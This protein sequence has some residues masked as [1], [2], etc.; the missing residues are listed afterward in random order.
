[1]SV[2][3]SLSLYLGYK[4]MPNLYLYQCHSYALSSSAT[5]TL[6]TTRLP[7]S[8]PVQKQLL[9]KSTID[10]MALEGSQEWSTI[11][12]IFIDTPDRTTTDPSNK[13]TNSVCTPVVDKEIDKEKKREREKERK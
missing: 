5:V 1:V 8:L 6:H 12:R 9:P 2:A 10:Q 3:V 7:S 13:P 4:L 11:K